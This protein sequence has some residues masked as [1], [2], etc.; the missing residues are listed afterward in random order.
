MG[1]LRNL[2]HLKR[3]Q[4]RLA[5]DVSLCDGL[6][7]SKVRTIAGCD[8]TFINSWKTPTEGIACIV[9]LTFPA[10]EVL[11]VVTA[12]ARVT[13][14]YVPGFLAYRELPL[15]L[16]AYGKMEEKADVFLIDGQGIAH[17]R[18][19]GIAAHFG[20]VTGEM[21]I[22]C[23]KSWLCGEYRDPSASGRSIGLRD[24]SGRAI[25]TVLRPSSGKSLLFVS[26]GHLVSVGTSLKIVKSCL[27][28]YRI[29]EP[30][31]LAHNRLTGIR[32]SLL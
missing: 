17:P 23:A 28:G 19:F 10:M 21:T 22:G 5:R 13:F 2:S 3:E 7:L 27:K 26:P 32:R 12:H 29:P 9:R 16:K 25:G 30:T 6:D 1:S 15:L 4:E 20:V 14:P 11:E 24:K 18:R 31:R 8:L